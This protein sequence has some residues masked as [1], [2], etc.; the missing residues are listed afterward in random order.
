MR[1]ENSR[2][3]HDIWPLSWE[4]MS[5]QAFLRTNSKT[6]ISLL[7]TAAVVAFLMVVVRSA[8]GPIISFAYH[9]NAEPAVAFNSATSSANEA[10]DP[11]SIGVSLSG[12]AT[13]HTVTVDFA[14][15]NGS[16]SAGSDYTA[17]SGTLTF[18]S[19]ATTASI[20]IPIV[21]DSNEESDDHQEGNHC[22]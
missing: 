4:Q 19:G 9:Y 3:G 21:N 2:H 12:V 7:L 17:T 1:K 20:S 6:L 16:G 8:G 15:S 11:A 5:V 10:T 22:S 14:T 13:G 18:T